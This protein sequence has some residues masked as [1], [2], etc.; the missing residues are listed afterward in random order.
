MRYG[1]CSG[2]DKAARVKLIKKSGFDYIE[3]G[4]SG[5][6][7]E[8]DEVFEAFKAALLENDIRCEAANGFFPRDYLILDKDFDAAKF[9]TYI[10]NGMKR[11]AEIGLKTV[12]FGSGKARAIPDGMSYTEA[13]SRLARFLGETV[14]PIA[15]KYGVTVVI[16]PLRKDESNII[17][18][19]KEGVILALMSGKANIA[20]LGD[21]YHMIGAGDTYDDI[22]QL[23]GSI[24][25]AH[26]SNPVGKNGDKR[27]YPLDKDEFDYKGFVDALTKAGCTRCSIEAG[28]DDFDTEIVA[29]GKVLKSI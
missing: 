8:S 4:F 5:L 25:H 26:I 20:G 12:V 22:V 2:L 28:T 3:T 6:S 11:G 18:T 10:E 24:K 23:S 9:E 27:C 7:R 16:E 15:E 1:V 14:S 29:A 19:V 17:N 13:F 21:I